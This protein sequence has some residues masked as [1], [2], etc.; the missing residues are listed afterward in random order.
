LFQA[1]LANLKIVLL[2]IGHD[3]AGFGFYRRVKHHEIRV[4]ANRAGVGVLRAC[5]E[6]WRARE[7][8]GEQ[9]GGAASKERAEATHS[10]ATG[11]RH[12]V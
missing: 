6:L 5:G 4:H 7:K 11:S 1:I 12:S 3:V 10:A 2:Q 9:Y 8:R